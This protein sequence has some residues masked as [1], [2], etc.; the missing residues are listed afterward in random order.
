MVAAP[1]VACALL[2][3]EGHSY[4]GHT[5]PALRMLWNVVFKPVLLV[6]GTLVSMMLIYIIIA[7]SAEGFHMIANGIMGAFPS[8][9]NVD[10]RSSMDTQAILC[11]MVM[12]LYGTFLA[13]AFTKCFSTIY[14]IPEKVVQWLGGQSDQFGKEDMQ[15]MS[16]AASQNS[17]QVA[18]AG[19]QATQN[20]AGGAKEMT[21]AKSQEA[22]Q[23]EGSD[24]QMAQTQNAKLGT[25]QGEN[26]ST[27]QGVKAQEQQGSGGISEFS[28]GS[29]G[30][31]QGASMGMGAAKFMK[32]MKGP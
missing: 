12:T 2:V 10:P 29:D 20:V 3:P 1:L 17:Q 15:Q 5:L 16:Q 14:L 18:Q 8:A 28:A 25:A 7:Y 13:I 6:I 19:Q 23:V 21:G 22:S 11:L 31:M 4:W 30:V 24:M 27:E 26:S 9:G 32:D